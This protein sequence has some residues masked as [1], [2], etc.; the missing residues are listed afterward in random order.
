MKTSLKSFQ[1]TTV[2]WMLNQEKEYGGGLLF[3]EA[4]TGKT[5]CCL[6][7]IIKTLDKYPKTLILCP[8]G[9]VSNWENEILKHTDYK[10]NHIVKYVGSNRAELDLDKGDAI[11]Y[12]ASY[13]IV[14]REFDDCN[15]FRKGSLFNDVFSRDY[16]GFIFLSTRIER[17]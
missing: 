15:K 1:N 6:D 5:I 2:K 4:G 16:A 9:L 13:S 10:S 3:N 17:F 14:A 7:V 11:F 8:A 12:I